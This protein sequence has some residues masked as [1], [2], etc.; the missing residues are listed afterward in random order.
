[1]DSPKIKPQCLTKKKGKDHAKIFGHTAKGWIL[2]CC[3]CD[4]VNPDKD[5][6]IKKL[7]SEKLLL[8]N[9]KKIEDII[10]SEEWKKF[11][12]TIIIPSL[13]GQAPE[14]CKR[15]CKE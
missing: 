10:D 3:W 14:V 7:M 9:N 13:Y 4:V 12:D 15:K 2:P 1:M 11:Y 6:E 5:P 8:K